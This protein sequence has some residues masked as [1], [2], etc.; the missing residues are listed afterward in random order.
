MM[1]ADYHNSFRNQVT[2]PDEKIDLLHASLL[3]AAEVYPS[4]NIACYESRFDEWATA[5][6]QQLPDDA[7][8]GTEVLLAAL[9]RYLFD[10]LG[11]SGNTDDYYDPRNSYMNEVL[12]RR[13]GIPITL[14]VIYIELGRRL[15][16]RLYGVS[17]P[18]HF[19]VKLRYGGG[20]LVLDPFHG[21]I[22]LS[23]DDLTKRLLEVFQSEVDDL[24]PFL[25]AANNREILVRMLLNLKGIYHNQGETEKTLDIVNKILILDPSLDSQYRDRG[26]LLYSL[27]CYHSALEDLRK[28]LQSQPQADDTE[29]IRQLIIGLQSEYGRLN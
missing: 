24:S 25:V 19:L 5:I 23:E 2:V 7:R 14:S 1:S 22:S 15:G 28:Y 17:F 18:G 21:G 11:F 6:R 20:E 27:E 8:P 10:E 9:N 26:L 3:I 12:D 29:M 13:R 4:L 16:L